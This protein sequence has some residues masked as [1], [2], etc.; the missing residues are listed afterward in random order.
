M[1]NNPVEDFVSNPSSLEGE[2]DDEVLRDKPT[3]DK[4]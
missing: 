3:I 4:F 1:L 2:D